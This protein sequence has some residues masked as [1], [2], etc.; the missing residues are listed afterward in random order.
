MNDSKLVAILRKLP[1]YERKSLGGHIIT[2]IG[3]SKNKTFVLYNYIDKHIEKN[4]KAL[5]KEAIFKH[6]FPDKR[7]NDVKMRSVMSA[8][9]KKIQQYLVLREIEADEIQYLLFLTRAFRRYK[10]ERGD[11]TTL[12]AIS[13]KLQNQPY[14][15]ETYLRNAYEVQREQYHYTTKQGRTASKDLLQN[16]NNTLDLSYLAEKLK[17]SCLALAGYTVANVDYDTGLLKLVLQHLEGNPLLDKE[18]AIGLYFY[19]FKAITAEYHTP[20]FEKLKTGL[21][22]NIQLFPDEDQRTLY[23]LAT[24]YCIREVNKG[25]MEYLREL[26]DL[27]RAALKM[28]LLLE[29]AQISPFSYKNIASAAIRLDEFE[30][31]EQFITQYADK[32]PNKHREN[33]THFMLSKLYY[34]QKNYDKAMRRLSQVE[35]NDLFLNLDAKIL[36]LKIYYELN[37]YDALESYI[38]SSYRFLLR[39][40]IKSYHRENYANTISFIKKLV[41]VNPHDRAKKEELRQRIIEASPLGEKEWLLGQL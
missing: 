21:T 4:K 24:N 33:Y 5:E 7:Y 13:L 25:H 36:L 22:Q 15:A 27:Y 8:L 30:W 10:E 28:D 6:F 26:F 41:E 14:R 9:Y 39:Q 32:L 16:L 35:Y 38:A 19:C 3:Q 11:K 29:N 1:K 31:A 18:P 12:K 17:Y 34:A 23:L 2:A 37:E 20:Y 40:K